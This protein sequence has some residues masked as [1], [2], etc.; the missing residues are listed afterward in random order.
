MEN[1]SVRCKL[2]PR[3]KGRKHKGKAKPQA[4]RQAKASR[5]NFLSKVTNQ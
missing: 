2:G 5:S 3:Q 1:D 4:V